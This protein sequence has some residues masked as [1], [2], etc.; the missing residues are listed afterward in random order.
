MTATTIS[1]LDQR[2][3]DIPVDQLDLSATARLNRESGIEFAIPAV[4][5]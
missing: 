3:R 5:R 4:S 1:V 2:H